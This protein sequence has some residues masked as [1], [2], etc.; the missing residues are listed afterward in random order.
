MKVNGE[1]IFS[2]TV[3]I[4]KDQAEQAILEEMLR[5]KKERLAQD[6]G[7]KIA[8]EKGWNDFEEHGLLKS[9][10]RLYVFTPQELKDFM[11]LKYAHKLKEMG[12]TD[13]GT[14]SR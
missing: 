8:E 13:E 9:E 10:I 3:G 2:A 6:L 7:M 12:I 14:S 1:I 5:H 11:D 4:D